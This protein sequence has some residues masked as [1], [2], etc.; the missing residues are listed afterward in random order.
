MTAS[1]KKARKYR[2][3]E[4]HIGA[5]ADR[6]LDPVAADRSKNVG[7]RVQI[8]RLEQRLGTGASRDRAAQVIVGD[9]DLMAGAGEM[10]RRRPAEIAIATEN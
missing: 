8:R 9:H 2:I 7:A 1:G 5:I 4:H 6:D 10:Q 3:D